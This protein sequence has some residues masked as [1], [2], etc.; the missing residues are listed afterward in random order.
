MNMNTLRTNSVY[1]IR[2]ISG[3]YLNYKTKKA[4]LKQVKYLFISECNV[5]T[6]KIDKST[7]LTLTRW[8][9]FSKHKTINHK[10]HHAHVI[11]HLG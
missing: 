6:H 5:Q 7:F 1:R 10:H 11:Q 2:E 4:T 9:T 3:K 8:E